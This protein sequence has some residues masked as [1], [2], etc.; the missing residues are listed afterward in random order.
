MF[1]MLNNCAKLIK[2]TSLIESFG[3]ASE[4]AKRIDQNIEVAHQA[5]ALMELMKSVY[6]GPESKVK[7]MKVVVKAL[8]KQQQLWQE[9]FHL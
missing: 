8:R 9:V 5:L 6:E 4:A 1:N 7:K 3:V 2:G